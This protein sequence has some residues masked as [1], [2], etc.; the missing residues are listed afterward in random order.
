MTGSYDEAE[1]LVQETFLRAWK[2]IDG[3]AGR[4]SIRTWLYRIATNACLDALDGRSRRILPDQLTG[5]PPADVAWLQPY[6][7]P[8]AAAVARETVELAFVVAVQ[9]LPPRQRAALILRDVLGW[10]ATQTA[11][12]LDASVAATNSALQ[13]AR[14]TLRDHL[15]EQRLEWTPPAALSAA[16][17]AVV[18]RYV[19]ALERADLATIA[20]LLAEDVRATMPPYPEWFADRTAVMAALTATWDPSS[21]DW[22]GRF[23]A[24]PTRANGR[25][26]VACWTSRD[27]ERYDPFALTVLEI[28]GDRVVALTAFHE[29]HLFAAFGLPMSFPAGDRLPGDHD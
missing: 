7:E 16:E 21:P 25:P 29:S 15:P 12:L 8:D 23:R 18:R 14:A 28:E 1:D 10:P 17:R 3:F 26:A 4:S 27:G 2:N 6:P 13:R 24:V 9:H 5:E 22:V 11:E 19:A 20:D